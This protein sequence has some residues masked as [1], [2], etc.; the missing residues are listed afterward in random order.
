METPVA[1]S[2][3]ATTAEELRETNVWVPTPGRKVPRA[4]PQAGLWM[5]AG[6]GRPGRGLPPPSVVVWGITIGNFVKTHIG[7]LNPA[8]W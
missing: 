6:G 2:R 1:Y 8:F 3:G 5:G 4:R 7:L